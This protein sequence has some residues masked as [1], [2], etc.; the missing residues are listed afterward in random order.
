MH[1]I[2]TILRLPSYETTHTLGSS[3]RRILASVEGISDI[4]LKR[5]EIDRATLSYE[6]SDP[7]ILW[8]GLDALLR[9][10]GMRRVR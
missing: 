9:S 10:C 7:G 6:W 2:I 8:G 3:A 4:C 1:S 5:Q